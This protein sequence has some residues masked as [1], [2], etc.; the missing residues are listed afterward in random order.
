M[1][2]SPRTRWNK[3]HYYY[4][5]SKIRN[6]E[7]IWMD[8]WLR[9]KWKYEKKKKEKNEKLGLSTTSFVA[10][11]CGT[12][13]RVEMGPA[14]FF[15]RVTPLV[16]IRILCLSS[17]YLFTRLSLQDRSNNQ[18]L[19]VRRNLR[20]SLVHHAGFIL[21]RRGNGCRVER[22]PAAPKILNIHN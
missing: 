16:A 11:P 4:R 5:F 2:Q 10:A 3:Y 13:T 14:C 19:C 20:R 9:R 21:I 12:H 6:L 8:I 7:P 15:P 22:R 17:R 18:S 1:N